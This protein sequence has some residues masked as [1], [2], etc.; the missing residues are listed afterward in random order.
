MGNNLLT[1]ESR[2]YTIV[3]DWNNVG[4]IGMDYKAVFPMKGY[5]LGQQNI[6]THDD[7]PVADRSAFYSQNKDRIVQV[8]KELTRFT[9]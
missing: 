2:D 7:A 1:D 5:R 3:C 9:K 6:T 8:M 4:F